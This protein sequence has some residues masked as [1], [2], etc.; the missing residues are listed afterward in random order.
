MTKKNKIIKPNFVRENNVKV[1][2]DLLTEKPASCLEIANQ[3]GISDVGANKIIKQLLSFKMVKK[4]AQKKVEKK[5]G[6]Q[7]IRYIVNENIGIYVCIDFTEFVDTAYIYDFADNLIKVIKFDISYYAL[8]SEIEAAIKILRENLEEILPN[9]NNQLLGIGVSVPGQVNKNT[10]DFLKSAKFKDF[11]ENELYQM[12]KNEFDTYI[13]IRHNVQLMAIGELDK[14][15]LNNKYE[16][17]TYVYAGNGLAACVLFEGKNVSGWRGYAGEIAGNRMYPDTKLGYYC[18][19]GEIL[20]KY[21]KI[22]PQITIDDLFKMYKTDD[23][24]H[25]T[26][27]ESA[28]ILAMFMNNVTNLLGCNLFMISGMTLNFGDEYL[29]VIKEYLDTHAP[30]KVEVIKSSLNNASI[31]GAMK[32][33]KDFVITDYYK[34]QIQVNS[35]I[36]SF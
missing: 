15:M 20:K 23:E 28:K 10:N 30:I 36:D 32:L 13:I 35:N 3:I 24:F 29:N 6:G 1:I 12:L 34:K 27:N 21:R 8:V 14:G 4:A 9:Y 22:D 5:I 31:M 19:L 11:K 7:H 18:S 26:I 2:I 25:K 17:A 33:L 16:I